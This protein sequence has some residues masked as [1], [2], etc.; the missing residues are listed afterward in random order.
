MLN[1]DAE[2]LDFY[3]NLDA[4]CSEFANFAQQTRDTLVF[5]ADDVAAGGTFRTKAGRGVVWLSSARELSAG[6]VRPMLVGVEVTRLK[7]K[8][9]RVSSRRLYKI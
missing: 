2:H 4:I 1:V 8:Q 3:A 7:S 9:I 6:E 5:C